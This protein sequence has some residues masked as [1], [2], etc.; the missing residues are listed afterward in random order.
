MFVGRSDPDAR[1]GKKLLEDVP[2]DELPQ[3]L[4]KLI[5]YLRR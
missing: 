5:P 2:Y 1:P 4:E 3:V